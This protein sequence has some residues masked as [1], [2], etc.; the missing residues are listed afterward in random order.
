[1][2]TNVARD[3]RETAEMVEGSLLSQSGR[4]QSAR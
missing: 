1:M 2:S 3:A 4:L